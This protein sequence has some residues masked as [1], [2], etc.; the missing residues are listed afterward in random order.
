MRIQ[1]GLLAVAS[2]FAVGCGGATSSLSSRAGSPLVAH[3]SGTTAAALT[4]ANTTPVVVVNDIYLS[5]REFELETAPTLTGTQTP[6]VQVDDFAASFLIHL[7]VAAATALGPVQPTLTGVGVPDGNYSEVK[8][9]IGPL[10]AGKSF[11]NSTDT[12]T[13]GGTALAGKSVVVEG[14]YGGVAFSF[15]TAIDFSQEF[16]G[17]F[18]VN[19]GTHNITLNVDPTNWFGQGTTTLDPNSA[20]PTVRA[21]IEANIKKS[22]LIFEDDDK[23]GVAD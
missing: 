1:A 13:K 14:T 3:T 18:A 22:F 6:G 21:Q 2:L 12:T 9:E 15:A 8:F 11:A 16:A 17:K 10:D 7:D 5:V 19:G 4:L 23:D 20:D